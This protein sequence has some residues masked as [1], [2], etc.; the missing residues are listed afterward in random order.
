MVLR[1]RKDIQITKEYDKSNLIG[2]SPQGLIR[3]I[4]TGDITQTAPAAAS[5][6]EESEEARNI[7]EDA[8][9]I[10]DRIIELSGEDT[11]LRVGN[12]KVPLT[13]KAVEKSLTELADVLNDYEEAVRRYVRI[14]VFRDKGPYLIPMEENDDGKFR[15]K[16]RGY[17]V[18]TVLD[19]I[20]KNIK[21]LKKDQ[22]EKI[23]KSDTLQKTLSR[24]LQGKNTQFYS[25][26]TK[27]KVNLIK[28]DPRKLSAE[29]KAFI[30]SLT[31][32]MK[33]DKQIKKMFNDSL[34]AAMEKQN[35]KGEIVK[36]P[37]KK[38]PSDKKKIAAENL[39]H[40]LKPLVRNVARKQWQ[41]RT[42]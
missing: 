36:M 25:K 18:P 42:T 31:D 12:E 28:K 1:R 5:A 15:G 8:K 26:A 14:V 10:Y 4:E 40:L 11:Q 38:A 22:I 30:L 35:D 19:M 24:L 3:A 33:Q 21:G 41:K 13:P 20:L 34:I 2:I 32:T 29:T 16:M 23:K 39:E 17:I 37:T 9:K 27:K 7:K 6:D